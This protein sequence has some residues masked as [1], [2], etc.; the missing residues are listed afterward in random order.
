MQRNKNDH[1]KRTEEDV[2][3]TG[4][5]YERRQEVCAQRT[6]TPPIE[7]TEEEDRQKNIPQYGN[8]NIENKI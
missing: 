7:R 5:R 3:D 2:R 4:N 6:I 8:R 1:R